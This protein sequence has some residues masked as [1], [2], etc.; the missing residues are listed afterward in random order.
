MS[1]ASCFCL[2]AQAARAIDNDWEK[3]LRFAARVLT[4][5]IG[6]SFF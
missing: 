1:S 4:L 6:P 3:E 5:E 2:N